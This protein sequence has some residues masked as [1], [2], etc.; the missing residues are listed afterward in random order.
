VRVH[1][2]VQVGREDLR[3]TSTDF[4]IGGKSTGGQKYVPDYGVT[5]EV[6]PRNLNLI[7]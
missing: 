4:A 5:F 2:K 7:R 3:G 6:T 1:I